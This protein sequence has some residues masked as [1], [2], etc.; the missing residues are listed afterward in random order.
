[1]TPGDDRLRSRESPLTR[2]LCRE[3]LAKDWV[4][5]HELAQKGFQEKGR[6]VVVF[7][8]TLQDLGNRW[9]KEF[10][11]VGYTTLEEMREAGEEERF[12]RSV[13]TYDTQSEA[14]VVYA[15]EPSKEVH[16]SISTITIH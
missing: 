14:A 9:F 2:T 4:K 10:E 16:R 12:C 3:A 1:M 6:G 8:F 15:C 11:Y 7:K 13:E 5:I